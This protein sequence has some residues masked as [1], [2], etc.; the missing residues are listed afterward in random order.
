MN[1]RGRLAQS[2]GISEIYNLLMIDF[3]WLLQLSNEP[4]AA[5]A[6]PRI[7]SMGTRVPFG[8]DAKMDVMDEP[9]H[10]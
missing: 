2:K 4:S 5:I 1:D 7:A 3:L 9:D 6:K 10:S 8:G